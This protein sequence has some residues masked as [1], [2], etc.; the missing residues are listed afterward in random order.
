MRDSTMQPDI[1]LQMRRLNQR[2]EALEMSQRSARTPQTASMF[3]AASAL[4]VRA[5]V[6]PQGQAAMWTDNTTW[7]DLWY[8]DFFAVGYELEGSM[9]NWVSAGSTMDMQVKVVQAGGTAQVVYT[10]TGITTIGG[11][12][13]WSATIPQSALFSDDIRGVSIRVSVQAKVSAG[14][15]AVGLALGSIPVNSP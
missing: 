2:I 13:Y 14:T 8:G 5:G 10:E 12:Q 11:G 6:A 15:L 1:A 3:A 7:T 9:Y 4:S